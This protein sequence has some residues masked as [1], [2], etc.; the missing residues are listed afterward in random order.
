MHPGPGDIKTTRIYEDLRRVVKQDKAIKEGRLSLLTQLDIPV[1]A[2]CV[3]YHSGYACFSQVSSGTLWNEGKGKG[4]VR[5]R[6]M[7]SHEVLVYHFGQGREDPAIFSCTRGSKVLSVALGSGAGN[8]VHLVYC[9][10]DESL[11]AR[12]VPMMYASVSTID[13]WYSISCYLLSGRKKKWHTTFPSHLVLSG[14]GRIITQTNGLLTVVAVKDRI[15]VWNEN[16]IQARDIVLL[17]QQVRSLII[18]S[19]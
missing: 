19:D 15:I 6:G 17:P 14:V 10:I 16:G 11:H 4:K 3:Q 9:E 2:P 12:F 13:A 8:G 7:D 5:D 1:H 18:I